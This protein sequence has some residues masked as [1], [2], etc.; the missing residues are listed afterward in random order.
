MRVT[1][2]SSGSAGCP[3]GGYS[4]VTI[5][6]RGN[7]VVADYD[8]AENHGGSHGM[9]T[10]TWNVALQA[11]N[12]SLQWIA[13]DLC[14]HYW[15]QRIEVVAA[16]SGGT[17]ARDITGTSVS[18]DVTPAPGTS[19]WGVEEAL[20]A[21]LDDPPSNITGPNGSWNSST[22]KI[23]WYGTGDSS[24]T[25]GY[26]VS[27]PQ[28]DYVVSGIANF[29]GGANVTIDG[30][31]TI[32]RET[33]HPADLN[34]DWSMVLS[35]AIGYAAGWQQ[36]VNP[37]A[38]AIRALYLWQ[39]GE[40]YHREAGAEPMCWVPDNP[41]L[42]VL[43]AG[44][45][46]AVGAVRTVT[47]DPGTG[48]GTVSIAVE[49]PGGTSAWGCEEQIPADVTPANLTGPNASWNASTR[50][51]TWYATSDAPA[52]LGYTV[53]GPDN[54]YTLAGNVNFD[55]GLDDPISG[56]TQVTIGTAS[57]FAGAFDGGNNRKYLDWFGWYNDEYWPW[58]W[59]YEYGCWLWVVDNGPQNVWFWHDTEQNWMWTR[60]DWYKWV[61]L[62]GD[63][64]LT[65]RDQ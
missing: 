20:P 9:V 10:D 19:A 52:T 61:W 32:T 60:T 33:T 56:D 18:I 41:S 54:T 31:D 38:Y 51:I 22:R 39:N 30:P 35:E 44:Q 46:K 13:G 7:T 6:V 2:L 49:P 62:V 11:G 40:A 48:T 42:G 36:G 37:L 5:K 27:G 43:S 63:P 47:D 45:P 8:P 3:G 1:H 24:V 58:I 4:P 50:K 64:G 16:G 15:I 26:T 29:D 34:S 55:G 28:G 12:N 25:L 14:T 65:W 17:A 57:A 53:T 59:D 21:G 23:T